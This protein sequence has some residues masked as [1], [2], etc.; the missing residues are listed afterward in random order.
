MKERSF[1]ELAQDLDRLEAITDQWETEKRGTAR[2]IR[3]TVEALQAEAFRRLIR[4]IKDEPGGLAALKKAVDDPWV[5]SVLTFHG[6]LRPPEPSLEEKVERALTQVRPTLKGHSGDVELVKVVSA[7]EVHIRLVGSCDGCSFSEATVR[8]GIESAIRAELPELKVLK[9][10]DPGVRSDGLVQLRSRIDGSPYGKP[11]QDAGADEAIAEGSLHS[12]E[13]PGA[14][15]LL[16]RVEG[17]LKAFPNACTHL[18]MP[19]DGG[20]VQDGVLECP[21]HQFRYD[22]RTGECLTALEV[23]LVP[24]PVRTEH[25]RV[26]VQVTV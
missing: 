7:E 23:Q 13:L 11:W 24:L 8:I 10:V 9:V 14:S 19:L 16:T 18:G 25:G 3:S 12:V 17:T 5:R 1:A 2:A 21:F 26:L 15:V 20:T 22:L 6:L 4:T